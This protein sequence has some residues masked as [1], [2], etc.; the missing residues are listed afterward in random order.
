MAQNPKYCP[1]CG[2]RLVERLEGDRSRPMCPGCGFI[3]YL[4]PVVAAAALVEENGRVVLIRR[5]V[6][7]RAGYWGL[8][9]GYVEADE[10]AEEAAIRETAEEAGIDIEIDQLLDVYS[11][12][13]DDYPRGVLIVYSA[14]LISGQ[15]QAGDDASDAA[16]FSPD[17]LPPDQ[18]IAFWTHRN[19]L[20]DWRRARAINY[21]P[22]RPE[23]YAEAIALAQTHQRPTDALGSPESEK[24]TRLLLALDRGTIVGYA[25]LIMERATRARIDDVFVTPNYRRWGIGTQLVEECIALARRSDASSIVAEIEAGNPAVAFYLKAGFQVCG[26]ATS[27]AATRNETSLLVACSI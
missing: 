13:G 10:T 27:P 17:E 26:F 19:A 18:K 16:F 11:F 4:N 24:D 5:G 9:A 6:A 20:K 14:H 25:G 1:Q 7:P 22:A 3:Y 12:G 21:R 15:L 23:E 2:T 8:P